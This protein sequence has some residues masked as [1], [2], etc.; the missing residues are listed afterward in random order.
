MLLLHLAWMTCMWDCAPKA[1]ITDQC[2]AMKNAIED[3]FSY[4]RHR[5]CI[6]HIL[7]KVPEKLGMYDAY[8]SILS[9]LHNVVY[10]SLTKEEFE[11]VWEVFIKN[12][13]FQDNEWL[14]GLYSERNRWA[15]AFVKDVFW[16]KISST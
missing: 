2:M 14:H 3:V 15:P 9:S 5:W 4:T 13:E 8:K 16:A 11:E 1:I 6:W 12:Y 7:K 10:D